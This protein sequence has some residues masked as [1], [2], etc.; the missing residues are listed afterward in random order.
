MKNTIKFAIMLMVFGL[1]V[2]CGEDYLDVNTDPNNP[3][4]VTPALI[5][6][7]AQYYTASVEQYDRRLNMLGNMMM[8]N[9]SQSDGFSW[10]TDETKYNVTSSFYQ[11]VFNRTYD[12]ALKQYNLL[13]NFTDTKYVYYK[14][15]GK[16]MKAFHF[17]LMVDCYGDV[18]YTEALGR[19]IN[20]TPKYDDAQTIYDDLIV[21]LTAAI[22]LIK[23]ADDLAEEPGTDDAMFGGDMKEWI[24]FANT[25]K[26]RIL[27]R[28]SSMSSKASYIQ[29]ELAAIAAEGSGYIT[30]DIGVNPGF[31]DG[32]K[33][34]MNIM[35]ESLGWDYTGAVSMNY[36]ATCATDYIINYLTNTND[37]RIDYIYEKPATGHLG[38]PQG[39]LDY[40]TPVADVYMPEFVSNMGPG[41]MKSSTM[42][43]I[44]MTLAESYFNQAEL[45]S[46]GLATGDGEVLY[47]SGVTASFEYLGLTAAKATTYYTQ[48]KDLVNWNNSTNKIQA[49]I[50]QKWIATNGITAEQSWFDYSR[51]GYPSGLPVPMFFTAHPDRPVRLFYP[52][53]EYSS[54]GDNVPTQPDAFTEKIFWAK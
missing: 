42:D 24:K 4:T 53:G 20:P 30:T 1:L 40:D 13:D 16:I 9:W 6:P 49:I 45:V 18:P 26:L 11:Y 3:T 14:A 19:S 38:V 36:K 23:N 34:K 29:T 5:L 28:E 2:G 39:L 43:A 51:T 7:V 32:E 48:P 41:I 15:I 47:K 37:P 46:R 21:Q 33:D 31:I 22:D 54:N 12:Y 10:Y 50:T 35:W 44:I 8:Y 52:A 17:Q 27:T 25:V